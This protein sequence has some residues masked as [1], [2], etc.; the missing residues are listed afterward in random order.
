MS[1]ALVHGDLRD[2][3]EFI[4]LPRP[5]SARVRWRC[6][7]CSKGPDSSSHNS[8]EFSFTGRMASPYSPALAGTCDRGPI[9]GSWGIRLSGGVIRFLGITSLLPGAAVPVLGVVIRF[10]GITSLL[11]GTAIP[12]V[13]ATLRISGIAIRAVRRGCALRCKVFLHIGLR[14]EASPCHRP[15]RR[16][17]QVDEGHLLE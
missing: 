16:Q 2:W 12:L 3:F 13:D 1:L 6:L 7:D 15:S 14:Q 10:L 5:T 11:F 8:I 17:R 9:R 4:G